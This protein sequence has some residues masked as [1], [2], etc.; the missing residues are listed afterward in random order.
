MIENRLLAKRPESIAP[1]MVL[2]SRLFA[3]SAKIALEISEN[4]GLEL[5]AVPNTSPRKGD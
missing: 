1:Q 4:K 3:R 5:G 2:P